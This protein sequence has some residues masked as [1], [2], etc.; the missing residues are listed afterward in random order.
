MSELKESNLLLSPIEGRVALSADYRSA[1][2]FIKAGDRV[3]AIV[4]KE[5]DR[6]LGKAQ[7]PS[8]AL[9]KVNIGD[10]V[11]IRLDAY[12]YEEFGSIIGKLE[13]K[14]SLPNRDKLYPVHIELDQGLISS[15]GKALRFDQQMT[16]VA[17][18]ITKER[19]F[20]ERIFDTIRK[21]FDKY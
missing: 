13:S 1:Q 21:L 17:E 10:K 20:I 19:R 18:I 16:G 7:L 3:M 9:G 2:Q 4:P 5:G 15:T 6:I 11:I 14:S 12:P 8:S